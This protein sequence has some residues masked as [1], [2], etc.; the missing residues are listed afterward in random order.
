[1]HGAA[2]TLVPVAQSQ[3]LAAALKAK[4]APAEL[5]VYP[6]LGQGLTRDGA[7][8]LAANRQALDKAASFLAATF[9][10][11]PIGLKTAAR[12]GPVY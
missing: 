2:D 12:R 5:V 6:G 10:P 7:P 3:A 11:G 4:G 8:D 9:P 1:M